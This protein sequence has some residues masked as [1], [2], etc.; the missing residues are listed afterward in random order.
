MIGVLYP[1]SGNITSIRDSLQR[2]DRPYRILSDTNLQG[3]EQILIP[4]QGRFATVMDYLDRH[5]WVPV[6]REWCA[7]DKPLLGICVGMQ[8]LLTESE[9]DPG[10]PGLGVFD[11]KVEKLQTPKTPMMGWARVR[12]QQPGWDDGAAYYVNSYVVREHPDTWGT[13]DYGGLFCGAIARG[14]VR[15]VQFHPEKSG[16]WG[17]EFLNQCLIS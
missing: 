13:T 7:A 1:N 3:I 5:G 12:W 8:I 11:G 2:L 9:E 16:V 4:G 14:N 17:K 10:V 15:A 6:L